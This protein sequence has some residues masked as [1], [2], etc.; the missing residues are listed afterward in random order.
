MEEF[1]KYANFLN[2]INEWINW[3]GLGVVK[4]SKKKF[5]SG[6]TTGIPIRLTV[7]QYSKKPAFRMDDDSIVDCHILELKNEYP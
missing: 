5:K 2:E 4:K 1:N 7:N 3:I 6:N